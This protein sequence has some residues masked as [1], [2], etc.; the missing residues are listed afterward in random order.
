MAVVSETSSTNNNETGTPQIRC[1]KCGLLF[2][3]IGAKDEHVKLE[4]VENK[5]PSGVG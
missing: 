5:Q 1:E 4:H 2:D 3:N